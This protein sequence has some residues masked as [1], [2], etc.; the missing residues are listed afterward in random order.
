M[1]SPFEKKLKVRKIT[2]LT[3]KEESNTN[4]YNRKEGPGIEN[5]AS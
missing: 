2:I 3:Y 4:N 1:N 5:D